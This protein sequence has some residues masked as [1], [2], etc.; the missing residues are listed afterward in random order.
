MSD[1]STSRRTFVKTLAAG[2]AGTALSMPSVS[3]G[4]IIGAN[5][6]ITL[7]MIGIGQMMRGHIAGFQNE[8]D[9]EVVALADVY[10][11]NLQKGAAIAGGD[12]DTYSDFRRIIERDDIDAVVVAT[13][14][15]WHA[16]PTVLACEAGKDVYVEK[17]LART[18]AEGR[19]MVEAARANDRIVQVGTQ[20]RAS[21][22]FEEAAALV[23]NGVLGTIHFVRTWNTSNDSPDGIGSPSDA[24]PPS[25][26]DWDFW[27]GPAPKRPFNANRFGVTLDENQE[28]TSWGSWRYFWD[29]GGGHMTDW[30][31]H[32]LDIVQWAMDVDYPQ[33]VSGIGDKYHLQDNRTTPDTLQVTY[34]YPTFTCVYENRLL[35][36]HGVDGHGNGIIFYGTEAT[37]YLSRAGFTITPQPGRDVAETQVDDHGAETSHRR[38]FL[39]SVKSREKP[40]SDIEIGHRSSSTAMLGNVALRTGRSI[41][42]DG[43]AERVKDDPE[44]NQFITPDYREPWSLDF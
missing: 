7:G 29:Y 36:D 4:R 31:V 38:D 17:P 30:G 10:E 23:R 8:P 3:Y 6:R 20:Q 41:Q 25:G 9:V 12:V 44:A 33:S 26:L 37:M 19:K 34:E 15:H 28:Y 39:N 22:H 14:D 40:R 42:W 11:P 16:I 5:E 32:W 27:L 1:T 2:A 18:I 21:R 13:P 24:Q 35:N 43:E